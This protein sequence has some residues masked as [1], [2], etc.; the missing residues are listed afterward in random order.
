M[1]WSGRAP[2]MLLNFASIPS[3]LPLHVRYGRAKEV[4]AGLSKR[5]VSGA[6]SP[7]VHLDVGCLDAIVF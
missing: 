6:S 3:R 1:C 4:Q 7:A 5:K 2:G